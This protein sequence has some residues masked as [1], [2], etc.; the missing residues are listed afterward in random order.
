LTTLPCSLACLSLIGVGFHLAFHAGWTFPLLLTVAGE[1]LVIMTQTAFR[2]TGETMLFSG[3]LLSRNLVYLAALFVIPQS[4]MAL[5]SVFL[6]RAGSVALLGAVAVAALRPLPRLDWGR[7]RDA[8]RYGFPLLLTGFTYALND[9]TDRWFLAGFSGVIAVGVY[10]LHLKLAAIMAQ[11]IVMPFGLWFP[12]ERFKRMND[13]DGGRGFFILTAVALSLICG[14][15]SGCVWLARDVLLPLI[16]PGMA[17]APFVLACCLGSVT[18]LALSHALNV[19]LLLPG[20]TGKNLVVTLY[21]VAATVVGGAVL[22]PLFGMAGAALAR[23][24]GGIVLVAATAVWSNRV[25][26]IAFPFGTILAYF[27]AAVVAALA[28]DSATPWRGWTGAIGA[29]AVWTAVTGLMALLAWARLRAGGIAAQ[30]LPS[31]L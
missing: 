29:L 4:Y 27:L 2:A 16:A 20:Y 23:L 17:A 5:G 28:I 1:A 11:A 8:L 13:P 26:P 6:A 22:V 19:G 15:L 9:M 21:A 3:I 12:P 31:V 14:Y 25:F 10:A 30:P 24:V 18:C 7:Y